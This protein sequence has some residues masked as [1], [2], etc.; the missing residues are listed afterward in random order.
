MEDLQ[1]SSSRKDLIW[2]LGKKNYTITAF[3]ARS[4]EFV[5]FKMQMAQ[6]RLPAKS[7]K[8]NELKSNLV[9]KIVHRIQAEAVEAD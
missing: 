6:G 2:K 4:G 1:L 9:T 8:V 7:G 5:D 3:K